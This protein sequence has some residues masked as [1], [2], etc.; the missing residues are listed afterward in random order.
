MTRKDGGA[1][2]GDPDDSDG[3]VRGTEV[4]FGA[5]FIITIL[6]AGCHML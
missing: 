1:R 5:H 4:H 2:Y 3:H 6:V